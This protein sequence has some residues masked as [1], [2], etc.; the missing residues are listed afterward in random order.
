M[1]AEPSTAHEDLVEAL[2][3]ARD[4]IEP[5]ASACELLD[6]TTSTNDVAADLAAR[7]A[8]DGTLVV[9]AVQTAGRGRRGRSWLSPAGCGLYVSVV[10]RTERGADADVRFTS[11][12]TITAGVG[13]AEGL[14]AAAGLPVTLK[15]PN[16]LHI[17]GRKVGGILAEAVSGQAG[18][19]YVVVGFGI[20]IRPVAWPPD[21]ASRATSLE[22]ELGALLPRSSVLV[23]ALSGFA[24]RL[25]DLRAG[26]S[27]A[28]LGRW[29]ELSPSAVGAR[30]RTRSEQGWR[31][32]RTAGIADDGA[33]LVSGLGDGLVRVTSADF[34]W[35]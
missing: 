21:L 2:A 10:L 4:R 13:L 5:F 20:N 28:I 32:G 26:R 29:R 16:D 17:H 7:G 24:A 23:E 25:R 22:A 18:V 30:V 12:I 33:L 8:P 35:V 11:L 31:D 1:S 27:D 6:T 3:R 9:A 19:E 14:A 15:W 34:E